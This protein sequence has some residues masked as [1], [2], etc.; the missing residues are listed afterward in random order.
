MRTRRYW[1]I[2]TIL[3]TVLPACAYMRPGYEAPSVTVNSFRAIPS[4]GALP[5]FKIGLHVTNPNREPLSLVGISYVINLDGYDVIKGVGKDLP[6]I[7]P[8]GTGQFT[9]TAV[10]SMLARIRLFAEL[11]DTPKEQFAYTL[12]AKL[13]FG[14]FQPAIRIEDSG[15]IESFKTRSR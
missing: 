5:N 3:I 10:A 12:K 8:Y 9:V 7:E 4:Q 2:L 1:A 14:A 11:L 6:V 15:P 13:D